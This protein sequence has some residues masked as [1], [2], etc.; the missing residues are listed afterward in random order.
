MRN[1]LPA[2]HLALTLV[3]LLWDVVLAGRIMHVRRAPRAF[4]AVTAL[5]GFFILPAVAIHLA[6][7]TVVTGR[8]LVLVSFLW[9]ATLLLFVVQA[10]LA[11]G[12]RL[13][14]PVIGLPILA[15]NVIIALSAALS[16]LSA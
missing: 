6:T 1:W 12:R 3:I 5:A 2:A 4:A 15:Y 9:P 8:A 11:V 10:M 16:V 14:N 13:V 7:S